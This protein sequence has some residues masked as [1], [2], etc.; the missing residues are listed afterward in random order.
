MPIISHR[1]NVCDKLEKVIADSEVPLK[2]KFGYGIVQIHDV[3]ENYFGPLML[4][5][6]KNLVSYDKTKG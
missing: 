6:N 2:E 5:Q 3:E 1:E 4:V